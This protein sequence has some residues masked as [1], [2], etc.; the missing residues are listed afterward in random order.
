[1]NDRVPCVPLPAVPSAPSAK[2]I[3]PE[4]D[5]AAAI[6]KLWQLIFDVC[7][8]TNGDPVNEWKAHLDRLTTL[9][10]KIERVATS[11]ASTSRA[12]TART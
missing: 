4:L 11:K 6:E 3:F 1:M 10:E 7:R 8:V 9:G 12:A 2:E 5:E